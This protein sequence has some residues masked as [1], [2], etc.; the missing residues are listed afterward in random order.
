MD[1]GGEHI[2]KQWRYCGS[3][4]VDAY[5]LIKFIKLKFN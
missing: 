1:T 3:N 2:G 4:A 5:I